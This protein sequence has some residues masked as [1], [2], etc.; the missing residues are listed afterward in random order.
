MTKA[1]LLK[2]PATPPTLEVRPDG[3][4][5]EL[6]ELPQW[7]AWKW[8]RKDERWTKLLIDPDTGRN[9]KVNSAATWGTFKEALSHHHAYRQ[10]TAGVGF[11]FSAGD[12]YCGIDLD[13]ARDID[14]G[15]LE[16]WARELLDWLAS[17]AE[18]S[19]TGTGAKVIIRGVLAGKGRKTPYR[20]GDVEVYDRGRFFA[21]T[22][23]PLEGGPLAVA[24]RQEAL[25]RVLARVWPKTDGTAT[26]GVWDQLQQFDAGARPTPFQVKAAPSV[27]ERAAAYL[28]TMEPAVSGQGGHNQTYKAACVLVQRFGLSEAEAWPLLQI[29]NASC[30]PPWSEKDLRRKLAE[31]MKDTGRPK[32]YLLGGESN[33]A[34]Q[35][36]HRQ[37]KGPSGERAQRTA[38]DLVRLCDFKTLGANLTWLWEGW[39]LEGA[40]SLLSAGAGI[41]KTR[42]VADLVRRIRHGLPWP[43]GQPM[44]LPRDTPIIWVPADCQF[45]ELGKLNDD[46][47]L[48]EEHNY[49]STLRNDPFAATN[50][51][52]A[53]ELCNLRSLIRLTDARLVFVDTLGAATLADLCRQEEAT[54]LAVPLAQMAAELRVAIIPLYHNNLSGKPIGVRMVERCRTLIQMEKTEGG[55]KLWVEKS[56]ALKPPPLFVQMGSDG[57]DYAAAGDTHTTR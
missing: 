51:D 15:Q 31:A 19:P 43:D 21:I 37:G 33:G 7:V 44:Q 38:A 25:N 1:E 32:G 2:A 47:D 35:E 17:Y 11:V 26:N 41:G 36:R 27:A 22:G 55:I 56:F 23:Q 53:M 57:N 13:E 29:W 16:P 54:R 10:R 9:A 3:I 45:G 46:F 52:S 8:V 28:A 18:I 39:I 5:A 12:P 40:M 42:F 49:S 50:L 4:P 6:R 14:T 30:Q 24:E 34:S 48:G 20:T